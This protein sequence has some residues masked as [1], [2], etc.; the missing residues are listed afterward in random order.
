MA[1]WT[2]NISLVILT[3]KLTFV[4]FGY[5]ELTFLKVRMVSQGLPERKKKI[6]KK[7][8]LYA[9]KF[10]ASDLETLGKNF[11]MDSSKQHP[12]KMCSVCFLFRQ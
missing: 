5:L 9:V 3:V 11:L 12:V 1:L 7:N 2:S 8:V 4:Y 6:L 10:F